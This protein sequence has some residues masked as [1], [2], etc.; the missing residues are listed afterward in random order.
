MAC[1]IHTSVRPTTLLDGFRISILACG[2]HRWLRKLLARASASPAP[3]ISATACLLT[4]RTLPPR[5]TTAHLARRLTE[6]ISLR[7][8]RAIS[9]R[10]LESHGIHSAK[11]RLQFGWVTEST[12]TKS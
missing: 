2:I 7:R 11:E 8:P 5:L 12:T 9:R 6:N 3:E 4:R 1:A 10:G